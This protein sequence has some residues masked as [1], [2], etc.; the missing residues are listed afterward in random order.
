M[1][2]LTYLHLAANRLRGSLPARWGAGFRSLDTLRLPNNSL[3][4]AHL[5]R[6]VVPCA[7]GSFGAGGRR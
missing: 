1:S 7:V 3:T 4:G 5:A 6:L 2:A